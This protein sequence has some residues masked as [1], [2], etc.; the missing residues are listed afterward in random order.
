MP[1]EQI[2]HFEG[3]GWLSKVR[4]TFLLRLYLHANASLIAQLES[5]H[6]PFAIWNVSSYKFT[7]CLRTRINGMLSRIRHS[8][9]SYFQMLVKFELSVQTRVR[10]RNNSLAFSKN[11]RIKADY[12]YKNGTRRVENR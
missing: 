6:I 5:F 4:P 9:H 3:F 12:D 7:Y 10:N 8:K 11:T 2:T 1:F